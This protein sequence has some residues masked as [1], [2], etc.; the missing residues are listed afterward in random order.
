LVLPARIDDYQGDS[1]GLPGQDGNPTY[2]DTIATQFIERAAA[3]IV[4]PD[5][6]DEPD[7]GTG[8][9]C[10][11]RC[12][13]PLSSTVALKA[14]ADDC[15][16]RPRKVIRSDH[17]VS[18]DGAYHNHHLVGCRGTADRLGRHGNNSFS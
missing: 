14:R 6:S 16:A 12:V 7:C 4:F 18:V 8:A 1:R 11:H 15:L 13:C 5:R 10:S 9:G 2:I 17:E 3:S